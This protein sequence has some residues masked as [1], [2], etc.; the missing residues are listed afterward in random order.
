MS[1][2]NHKVSKASA[3]KLEWYHGTLDRKEATA[4]IK[5]SGSQDGLYLVRY[6]EHKGYVLSMSYEQQMYHFSIQRQVSVSLLN[7]QLKTET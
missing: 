5:N 2:A 7:C 3:C 4:L 6:S 1:T